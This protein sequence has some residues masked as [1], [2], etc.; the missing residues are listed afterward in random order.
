MHE[1]DAE[2]APEPAVVCLYPCPESHR[3]DGERGVHHWLYYAACTLRDA[4][5]EAGF[6]EEFLAAQITR[7]PM[8][9]GEIVATVA[10]VYGQEPNKPR[11]RKREMR[12]RPVRLP[13]SLPG[14]KYVL[15]AAPAAFKPPAKPA[16]TSGPAE[17]RNEPAAAPA[18]P[19]PNTKPIPGCAPATVARIVP[20]LAK[21][22]HCAICLSAEITVEP[23]GYHCAK[24][25][26]DSRPPAGTK[27]PAIVGQASAE[28]LSAGQDDEARRIA[29]AW[30]KVQSDGA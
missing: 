9:P 26:N 15:N 6:A 23:S 2:A 13:S 22:I 7:D 11:E 24:C 25:G 8:P 10:N 29:A 17:K 28:Q 14:R 12:L 30:A 27:P 4:G 20:V 3:G 21:Q 1:P 5:L 16:A 19:A 18:P